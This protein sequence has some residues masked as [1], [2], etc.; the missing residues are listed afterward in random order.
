MEFLTNALN[1]YSALPSAV[2]I[3]IGIF[4][5]GLILARL[6]VMEAL[7]ASIYVAGGMIG[8]N[9]M[10]GMFGGAVIP[11]LSQVIST[12]NLKLDI[13]DM[14]IGSMQSFVT[15]P[16]Q[17]YALLL[18]IG[19][20]VNILLILVKLT[21]TFNVDI[22][23]YFVYSLSSGFVYVQTKNLFLAILAFI[24]TE[25]VCLKLADIT[26]PSIQDAYGL[27]GVSIPH[28][29]AV[30]FAPIGLLV[31]W[32]IE[33]IPG[34][35]GID[36]SPEKIEEKFG[37]LVQPSTIGF[38][39]GIV[40]GVVGQQGFGGSVN[41]GL[42]IAAFM[43][44]FP[45]VLN[46]LI[47]GITPVADGMR[48]VTE[49]HL[50]R[51]LYIGLDAAILV[52]MPDVMSTGILLV[53]VILLLAFILPGNRVLPMADLAI[54]APFLV[55]CCMPYCKKNIFRGFISG[56]IVFILALYVCTLTAP[57]YTAVAEMNGLPFESISTSLGGAST[58]LSGVIGWLGGLFA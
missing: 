31:N 13:I 35:R 45:K 3:S 49:K 24:I 32:V 26:A 1:W 14:G 34:L 42:T 47:E 17:F 8:L 58:W 33:K 55:C 20:G 21:N 53:P 9:A 6:K 36:W 48:E 4:L 37:G 15:F 7:K 25:I 50:K 51:K 29:N 54:A 57:W 28:G 16:L 46:I 44:I 2:M 27:D 41:L 18:P 30:V 10:V 12:T 43:I 19:L 5:V 11:V 40:L 56:I 52:G 22:F 39:M 23:N 38:V